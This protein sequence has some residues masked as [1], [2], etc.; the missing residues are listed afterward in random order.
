[1]LSTPIGRL[2]L[3]SVLE[4]ITYLVLLFIAVPVKYGADKP[5]LVQIMGPVHGTFFILYV[6]QTLDVR[7]KLKWDGAMTMKVLVAAVIPFAPFVVERRLRALESGAAA[8]ARAK[9]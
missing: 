4:A 8:P 2:R 1:M 5:V 9:A 7:S 6:I 3:I